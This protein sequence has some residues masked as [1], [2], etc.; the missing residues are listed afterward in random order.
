MNHLP[1]ERFYFVTF[2]I[3]AIILSG[4]YLLPLLYP[5]IIG[6][7]LAMIIHQPV[8]ALQ[9]RLLLPRWLAIILWLLLL[10]SIITGIMILL[11]TQAILELSTLSS[12]LLVSIDRFIHQMNQQL[13]SSEWLQ[14]MEQLEQILTG[15]SPQLQETVQGNLGELLTSLGNSLKNLISAIF[16]Q[17]VK[18]VAVIPNATSTFF[19]AILSTFFIA[20]DYDKLRDRLHRMLPAERMMNIQLVYN[21]LRQALFGF[22]RAQFKLVSVTALLIM[23]GLLFLQVEHAFTIGMMMGMID[24]I[25][26]L[27][28]GV[29]M[30]PWILISF[31][32]ND[33]TMV[34][35]LSI[36]FG[37][38]VLV[39]QFM[40]PRIMATTIGLN[41]LITL[42]AL[43]VGL[44][45]FGFWGLMIGPILYV[46]LLSLWKA[47]IFHEVWS[48]IRN[49]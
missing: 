5:F 12:K 6:L 40:E 2:I 33:Y 25:P 21:D 29:I 32:E 17:L 4:L 13:Q 34:M 14:W 27:G 41:P 15:F 24:F 38:V 1:I 9:H 36:L 39:R 46:I 11:I 47:G 22:F 19:I 10:I 49:G 45:L 26:Y 20:L 30:I 7:I 43:F 31:I 42:I 3:L 16:G 37:I 48:Y 44:Q 8:T 18:F 35:G 23:V 28:V